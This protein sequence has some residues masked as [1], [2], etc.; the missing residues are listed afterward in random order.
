MLVAKLSAADELQ[1]GP[2]LV[3][4]KAVALDLILH[5]A[6]VYD[7]EHKFTVVSWQRLRNDIDR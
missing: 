3:D 7:Q 5:S 2:E 1:I 6:V 4:Q